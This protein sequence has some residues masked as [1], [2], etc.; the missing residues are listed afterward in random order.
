MI[1]ELRT[2]PMD[3][4]RVTTQH[5]QQ[6]RARA[7]EHCEYCASPARFASHTFEVDHILPRSLSGDSTPANL[8]YACRGCNGFKARRTEAKDPQTGELV[9]LYH[10]RQHLWGEH[11]KWRDDFAHVEGLTPTGRA[12]VTALQLNREGVVNLRRLLH[13]AGKHPPEGFDG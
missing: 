13:A 9:P 3:E 5:R 6:V 8:A 10:P 7:R 12:T 1:W 11:F 2:L 4:T